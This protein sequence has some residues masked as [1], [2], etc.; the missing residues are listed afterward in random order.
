MTQRESP[1]GGVTRRSALAIL[2]ALAAAACGGGTPSPKGPA[3]PDLAVDP[4]VDLLPAA[5]LVW[6]LDVH[7]RELLANPA[8]APA[9]ATVV[10]PERFEG[11]AVA[12]G[13]VDLRRVERLALADYGGSFVAAARTRYD[14]A[15]VEKA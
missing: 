3:T 15:A 14:A 6:L 9:V 8:L 12:H 7:A 13:G 11:F 1:S 5:G 10:P 4:L 2:G